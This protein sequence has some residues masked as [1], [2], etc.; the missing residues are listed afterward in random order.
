VKIFLTILAMIGII[1]AALI[2]VFIVGAIACGVEWLEN[3][4]PWIN[5]VTRFLSTVGKVLCW[6]LVAVLVS[7]VILAFFLSLYEKLWGIALIN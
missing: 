4:Y 1:I 5:N 6:V 7:F 3:K 2:T